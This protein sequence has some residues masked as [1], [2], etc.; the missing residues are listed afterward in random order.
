[1][2]AY[3]ETFDAGWLAA[4]EALE[5]VDAAWKRLAPELAAARVHSNH[6][7]YAYPARR[8]GFTVT[9][10][11][12]DPASELGAN[13]LFRLRELPPPDARRRIL[14]WTAPPLETLKRRLADEF[15]FV[16]VVVPT[17]EAEPTDGERDFARAM[18]DALDRLGLA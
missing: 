10:L 13:A 3:Q 16:S 2:P 18:L 9:D 11:D 6:Q 14:L 12:L 1:F 7:A 8:Y 17:L 4:S 15:G 5:A